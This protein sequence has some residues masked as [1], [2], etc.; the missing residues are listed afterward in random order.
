MARA[1][2]VASWTGLAAVGLG[3]GLRVLLGALAGHLGAAVLGGATTLIWA[4]ARLLLMRFAPHARE[5]ERSIMVTSWGIGLLP[6]L[7]AVSGSDR[8]GRQ[9]L[10]DQKNSDSRRH[11]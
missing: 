5:G 8:M 2:R 3:A 10:A 9:R 7:I 11:R 4:L 6:Y 1:T